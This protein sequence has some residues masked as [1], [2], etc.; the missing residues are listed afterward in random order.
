MASNDGFITCGMFI[1]EA[2]EQLNVKTCSRLLKKL[3]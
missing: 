3:S 2:S 1:Y